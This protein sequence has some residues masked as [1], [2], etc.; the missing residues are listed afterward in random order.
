MATS[1]DFIQFAA[2]QVA[3]AGDISYKK[4]FGEYMIYLDG[5]A[6]LLVCDDTVYVKQIPA[7]ADVFARHGVTP[8]VGTPYQGA[9]PHWVLDIEDGALSIDMVRALAAVMPAPK[10]RAKKS[11]K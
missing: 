2:D 6:V 9:K 3:T 4:M 11:V 10:P 1:T 8:D 7:A 5:R